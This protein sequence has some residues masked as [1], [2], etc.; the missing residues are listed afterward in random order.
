LQLREVFVR[1]I[2]ACEKQRYQDLTYEHHYF[3]RLP[4]IG[5]TL[6]YVVL[7]RK[8]NGHFFVHESSFCSRVRKSLCRSRY[9]QLLSLWRSVMRPGLCL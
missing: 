4:K 6:W 7:L 3:G 8:M 5:E 1:P 2:M 9:R